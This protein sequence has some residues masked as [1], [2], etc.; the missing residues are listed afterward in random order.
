MRAPHLLIGLALAALLGILAP[1][2]AHAT[3]QV[4]TYRIEH[5]TYGAIGT[6]TNTIAR[7]G[8]DATVRTELRVAVKVLGITVHREEAT[9]EEEWRDRRLVAYRSTTTGGSNTVT[10]TGKA[11]G[12]SFVIHSSSNG[13]ITAPANVHPENPWAQFLL[14]T[15]WM[16]ATKTGRIIRVTVKDTGEVTMDFNGRSLRVHQWFID[17]DG[18][19]VV[20]IDTRGV[21]VG[22][23][24]EEDG[25]PIKFVLTSETG[26][27]PAAPTSPGR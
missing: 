13:V 24:S 5:P 11:E 7:N 8:G 3:P 1:H 4:L 19:Q 14:D 23:Q 9:R 2:D 21:V 20:W 27:A 12:Q 25:T 22:F 16:M 18:H 15:D 10:V 6:Y 17:G 26:A